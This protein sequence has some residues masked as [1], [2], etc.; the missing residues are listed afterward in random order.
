MGPCVRFGQRHQ[1]PHVNIGSFSA[2]YW[3]FIVS[4]KTFEGFIGGIRARWSPIWIQKWLQWTIE[5]LQVD[6]PENVNYV[7]RKNRRVDLKSFIEEVF[8][9]QIRDHWG[10]K[11]LMTPLYEKS[12]NKISDILAVNNKKKQ[13]KSSFIF[14]KSSI[15][16]KL[17]FVLYQKLDQKK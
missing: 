16:F 6:F 3:K 4:D 10:R 7:V 1:I 15:I 9:V 2:K 14:Q 11:H 13:R 5:G 12:A 17:F 8:R